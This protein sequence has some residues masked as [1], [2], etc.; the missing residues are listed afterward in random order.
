MLILTV[1]LQFQATQKLVRRCNRK[2][3]SLEEIID[4]CRQT[5]QD[6]KRDDKNASTPL[7]DRNNNVAPL[8]P[9]TETKYFDFYSS[10]SASLDIP[11]LPHRISD[12]FDKVSSPKSSQTH[13]LPRMEATDRMA[14]GNF[15]HKQ[16]RRF[17]FNKIKRVYPECNRRNILSTTKKLLITKFRCGKAN[18]PSSREVHSIV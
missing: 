12:A 2:V 9:F 17:Y 10:T 7:P 11:K 1:S 6:F 15:Q 3:L 14:Q 18:I 8:N 4:G 16:N 13:F 5:C